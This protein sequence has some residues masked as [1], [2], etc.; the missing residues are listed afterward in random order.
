MKVKE[1]VKP[2]DQSMM[3][4]LNSEVWGIDTL[5]SVV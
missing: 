4:S 1:K 3:M 2:A 5:L